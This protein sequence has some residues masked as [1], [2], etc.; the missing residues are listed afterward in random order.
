VSARFRR[1]S[2]LTP[3]P[4][5][6]LWPE[7]LALGKLALLEGDPGLSKSFLALDLCAR[8][9]TGRPWPDGTPGPG[10]ASCVF[11]SG[12]DSIEDTIIP[13][14]HTLG[15]D[16]GRV[17]LL[18]R[19]G[20]DLD[21]PLSL[22]EHTGLVEEAVAEAQARLLVIDPVFA[23][24][25]P[26]VNPSS[27]PSVRRALGPLADL[28]RRHA[29]AVLLLRHLNK[30]PGARALYRGLGSIGLAGVCRSVWLVAEE[31]EGSCRR[32]LAQV[33]NNFA[34]PQPSLAYEVVRP[35][36]GAP[37][38]TWHGPVAVTA[39]ELQAR[40]RRRGPTPAA[41]DTAT[42]FLAGVLAGGPL[43]VRDI[44]TQARGKGLSPRTLRRAK[45][46]LEV[47]SVWVSRDGR[48]VSYWLLPGQEP[49]PAPPGSGEADLEE[50]L[51]QLR[52]KYPPPT[53]LDD[54]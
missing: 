3:Q 36:A 52:E 38:L 11:L 26:D 16:P 39:Q 9:T 33:K 7:R 6:W 45:D 51:R 48:P 41:R 29:C 4:L 40:A 37:T 50:M 54:M 35:A 23:F 17:L 30:W 14:L 25:G 46:E 32:V 24:F 47:R 44:W 49:P 31:A 12:E 20:G 27:D 53:P 43:P 34:G 10:P 2:D 28:A 19:H 18:D 22:P 21:E 13:R 42:A 15:A 8:L 5:A 1:L